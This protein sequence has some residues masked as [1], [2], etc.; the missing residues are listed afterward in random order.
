MRFHRSIALSI[1]AG[2]ATESTARP[3]RGIAGV[4]SQTLC[5][6]RTG[7]RVANSRGV[8]NRLCRADSK[9][10]DHPNPPCRPEKDLGIDC[11]ENP[12]PSWSEQM[13]LHMKRA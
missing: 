11:S 9:R 13:S 4:V 5:K 7:G 12:L 1:S 2:G 6:K 8:V 3:V 10:E